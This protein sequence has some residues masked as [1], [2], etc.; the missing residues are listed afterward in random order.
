MWD[1]E[2]EF[3]ELEG[4]YIMNAN[5][6][7][8]IHKKAKKFDKYIF[9]RSASL[10]PDLYQSLINH[11]LVENPYEHSNLIVKKFYEWKSLYF[12]P[13]RAGSV[14]GAIL[15][16]ITIKVFV[17]MLALPYTVVKVG[18]IP[19]YLGLLLAGFTSQWSIKILTDIA[20]ENNLYNY[21][22]L[23]DM[24]LGEF[25]YGLT[26]YIEFFNNYGGMIW[27]NI[28]SMNIL[29]IFVYLSNHNS[30]QLCRK[31]ISLSRLRLFI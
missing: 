9:E 29:L 28:L 24:Y 16:L 8:F 4:T 5:K 27:D 2:A 20:Y 7:E 1:N 13:I 17:V 15:C 26:H 12:Q 3:E 22:L 14:R 6:E 31:F 10:D 18:V 25:W 21:G 23:V 19:A 11:N 30:I